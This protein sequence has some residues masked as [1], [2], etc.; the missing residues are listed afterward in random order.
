MVYVDTSVMIAMFLKEPSS[1]AALR[2]YESCKDEL[3]SAV[4]CVTE[5]GS[6]LGIK[7]RTQQ[8]TVSQAKEAWESFEKLCSNDLNLVPV[9][10][11]HFF[12]AAELTLQYESALRA[13]DSLHLACAM[14]TQAK[15]IAT[16]D[17]VMA[18]NAKALKFRLAI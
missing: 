1:N 15:K 4:W 14:A 10:P 11:K 6:A 16:L 2:W 7:Q 8:I 9:E 17:E 18:K 5:F 12:K 13:G 3:V